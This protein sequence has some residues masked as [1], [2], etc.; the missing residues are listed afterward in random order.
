MAINERVTGTST[1]TPTTVAS[2]TPECRPSRLIAT[3]KANLKQFG[4]PMSAHGV[5]Q[6]H[7]KEDK[8][9]HLNAQVVLKRADCEHPFTATA[10]HSH[11]ITV[12]I[13]PHVP[14]HRLCV[15]CDQ[16]LS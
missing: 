5:I 3:A 4:L 10:S 7:A 15:Q 1:T 14:T 8:E 16:S 13:E 12:R 6:Q 11:G 2:A 9:A